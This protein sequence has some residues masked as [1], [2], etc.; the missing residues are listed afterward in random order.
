MQLISGM[1]LVISVFIYIMNDTFFKFENLKTLDSKEHYMFCLL[2][3]VIFLI[4]L[5]F[6]FVY[7]RADYKLTPKN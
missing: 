4:R 5:L 3:F 2:L 7:L 1:T 6:D